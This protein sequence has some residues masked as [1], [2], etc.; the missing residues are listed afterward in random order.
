MWK[1]DTC[2]RPKVKAKQI[3]RFKYFMTVVPEPS[4]PNI[5]TG[6]ITYGA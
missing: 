5:V 6:W 3:G 1:V 2:A 4:Q